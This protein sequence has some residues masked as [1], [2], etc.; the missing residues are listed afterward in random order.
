MRIEDMDKPFANDMF[1]MVYQAFRNLYNEKDKNLIIY[2]SDEP[3][4]DDNGNEVFGSTTFTNTYV[5]V[6][7]SSDLKVS[8]SVEILAHELA[9]VAV[10]SNAEHSEEWEKAFDAIFTEYNRIGDEMFGKQ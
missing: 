10:G 4:K 2:W 8:D 9:H 3:M 6:E 7:I 5:Y 1:A